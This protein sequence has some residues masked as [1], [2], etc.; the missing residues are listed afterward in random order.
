MKYDKEFK[1]KVLEV[2]IARGKVKEVAEEWHRP[3][4]AVYV[5]FSIQESQ[6][7]CIPRQ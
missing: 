3:S 6:R 4:N 5:A 2:S 1:L 7:D